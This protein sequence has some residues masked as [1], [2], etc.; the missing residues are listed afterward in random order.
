MGQAV[1]LPTR[2]RACARARAASSTGAP[3]ASERRFPGYRIVAYTHAVEAGL[4]EFPKSTTNMSTTLA[5]KLTLLALGSLVAVA[6]TV[7]A[8]PALPL[9]IQQD[10]QTPAG[11][12]SAAADQD[13]ADACIDASTPALP[14][15]PAVPAL[16][17]PVAV[18]AVPNVYGAADTCAKA[19]LDGVAID[20]NADAMGLKAGTGADLDTSEQHEQVKQTAGGVKGF[21]T[22]LADRITSLF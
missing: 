20:A 13:G 19:S 14:S 6:G 7:A 22:G 12:I 10:V 8:L 21:F 18:P 9:G 16:P 5:R 3:G 11:S 1:C 2:A 4:G 15:L 17:V